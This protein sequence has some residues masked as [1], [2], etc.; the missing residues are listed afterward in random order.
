MFFRLYFFSF[1]HLYIWTCLEKLLTR[2]RLI[3][4]SSTDCFEMPTKCNKRNLYHIDCQTQTCE[5]CTTT[6][7]SS[8]AS[9]TNN[10]M[11]KKGGNG[12]ITK[13]TYTCK[14]LTWIYNILFVLSFN[15]VWCLHPTVIFSK[16]SYLADWNKMSVWKKKILMNNYEWT[17]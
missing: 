3:T 12:R 10:L 5:N 7:W 9:D 1:V 6:F 14:L 11:A 4:N 8:A 17:N 15:F 13:T 2:K 16:I